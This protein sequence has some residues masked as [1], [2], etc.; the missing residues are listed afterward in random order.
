MN[1]MMVRARVWI[2]F[3][4]TYRARQEISTTYKSNYVSIWESERQVGIR[5]VTRIQRKFQLIMSLRLSF[6]HTL[7]PK[8][9]YPYWLLLFNVTSDLY[10]REVKSGRHDS[11]NDPGGIYSNPGFPQV[12]GLAPN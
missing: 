12:S 2:G 9:P 11:T 1:L 8:C 10:S 4:A 5:A 6:K 3:G 7:Y